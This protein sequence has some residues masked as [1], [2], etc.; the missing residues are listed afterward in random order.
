MIDK[1]I[2]FSSVFLFLIATSTVLAENSYNICLNE[3]TL[4]KITVVNINNKEFN[5]TENITCDF[6]CDS[7]NNACQAD[8]FWIFLALIIGFFLF[9]SLI[10]WIYKRS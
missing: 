2:I 6:G 10:F 4:N 8:P 5:I 1:K 3:T 9:F 7:V